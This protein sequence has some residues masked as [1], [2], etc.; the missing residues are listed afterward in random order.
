[1]NQCHLDDIGR[2]E[3]RED[4][5]EVLLDGAQ[6]HRASMTSNPDPVRTDPSGTT[7]GCSATM[8]TSPT[9]RTPLPKIRS[10]RTRSVVHSRSDGAPL[11]NRSRKWSRTV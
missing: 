1:L 5:S 11:G 6:T 9:Q 7:E 4:G 8:S 10:P 3:G 2:P